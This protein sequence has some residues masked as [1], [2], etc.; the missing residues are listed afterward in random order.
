MDTSAD[1]V[2]QN[3]LHW[4]EQLGDDP[5]T[6]PPSFT[7]VVFTARHRAS[8]EL[9]N[10]RVNRATAE[11]SAQ[12]AAIGPMRRPRHRMSRHQRSRINLSI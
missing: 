4:S 11:V 7:P 12:L 6:P 1:H 2:M 8:L 5:G 9:I 3:L 10:E